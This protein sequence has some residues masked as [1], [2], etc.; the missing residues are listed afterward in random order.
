MI[1]GTGGKYSAEKSGNS[2]QR[3]GGCLAVKRRSGSDSSESGSVRDKQGAN[4]RK[5]A[6]R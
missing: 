4:G 3:S 2:V 1:G 5:V 6:R